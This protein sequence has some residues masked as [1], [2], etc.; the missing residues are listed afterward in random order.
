M[1]AKK[2]NAKKSASTIGKRLEEKN[3]D[4]WPLGIAGNHIVGTNGI[5][6]GAIVR[7]GRCR[8]ERAVQ[9]LYPL[10]L[11]R[12]RPR[13]HLLCWMTD[14]PRVKNKRRGFYNNVWCDKCTII[15]SDK[16]SSR[17][18]H[19]K[20]RKMDNASVQKLVRCIFAKFYLFI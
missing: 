3:R 10:E 7:S 5:V 12:D 13:S 2:N 4:K 19:R 8:I 6:R 18:S 11:S 16:D 14:F 1:L 17:P 20:G 15:P 9:H